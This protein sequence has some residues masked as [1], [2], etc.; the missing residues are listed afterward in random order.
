MKIELHKLTDR[1]FLSH[2]FPHLAVPSVV[3]VLWLFCFI[4]RIYAFKNVNIYK[5]V[6][7]LLLFFFHYFSLIRS[8]FQ[9]SAWI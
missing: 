5:H 7:N 2:I 1:F 3:V 4:P 8:P 6:T 9:G